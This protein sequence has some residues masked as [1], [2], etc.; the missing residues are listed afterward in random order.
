MKLKNIIFLSALS[1]SALVSSCKQQE[2]QPFTGE[3]GVN[4][5]GHDT[6]GKEWDTGTNF[7]SKEINFFDSL[8]LETFPLDAMEAPMRIAIEGKTPT[9]D[10]KIKL[11]AL[12]V[13]GQEE[14]KVEL[15]EYVIVKSGENHADFSVKLLAPEPDQQPES[16]R[17][18]V[19]Y[20]NSDVVA[21]VKDRQAFTFTLKDVAVKHYLDQVPEQ[22]FIEAFEKHLGKYGPVKHR[23]AVAATK[24]VPPN[25]PAEIFTLKVAYS[26]LY[27]SYPDY[28]LP[29]V[30]PLY[31]KALKEYNAK[32]LT[33][34]KEA[35][36]TLVEFPEN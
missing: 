32:H 2:V 31:R 16:V 21:G 7:L 20:D 13:E 34:L 24:P 3:T 35:D 36:G 29:S 6:T 27:P 10:L 25:S 8:K 14:A 30:L 5:L 4:F 26:A 28:G 12:P 17:I 11:K 22:K 9:R 23:F 15:P 33:P 18:G 1:I 19:D